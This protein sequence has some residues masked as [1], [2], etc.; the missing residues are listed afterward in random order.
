MRGEGIS[1]FRAELSGVYAA[2]VRDVSLG[3]A[4]FWILIVNSYTDYCWSLFLKEKSKLKDKMKIAGIN[5]KVICCDYS[6]ENKAF[7]KEC[8]SKALNFIFEFSG[9]KTPQRNGKVERKFQIFYGRIRATLNCARLKDR[10]RNGVWAECAR[11]VTFL[12]NITALKS[13]DV[14]P[15]QLLFGPKPKSPES[16][17]VIGE[18]GV[19]TTKN[20]TQ[21][22]L[23]NRGTVCM[24][25]GYLVDHAHNAYHRLNLETNR[26]INSG[27]RG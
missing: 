11:T 14:C 4:N 18:V 3:G 9:P 20:N 27:V 7:Q 5:I 8:N 13:R 22:K 16:L 17:K 1:S 24:F 23:R 19:D 2:P 26:I 21:G 6:G 10:L 15:Y 25:V 12:S